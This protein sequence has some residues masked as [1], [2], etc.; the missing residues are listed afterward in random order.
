LLS[1]EGYAV[2]SAADGAEALDQVQQHHPDLILLDMLMPVVDGWGF[3]RGYGQL[4]GPKAPII[5]T[6]A[7]RSE[8]RAG[9]IGAAGY[10]SK[11]FSVPELLRSVAHHTQ[12]YS[13]RHADTQSAADA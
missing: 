1:D 3:A 5:V 4:P 12:A 13:D 9:E 8:E 6:A 7:T 11:P 2:L 10:C